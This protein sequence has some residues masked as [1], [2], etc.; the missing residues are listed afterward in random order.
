[1]VEPSQF[2][3]TWEVTLAGGCVKRH[4]RATRTAA[5]GINMMQPAA[6][7]IALSPVIA[8]AMNAEMIAMVAVNRTAVIASM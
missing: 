6:M 4:S 2:L 3:P 8:A 1:V 7:L 5:L